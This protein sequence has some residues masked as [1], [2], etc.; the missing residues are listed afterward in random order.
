LCNDDILIIIII[1]LILISRLTKLA[2]LFVKTLA[3]PLSKRIKHDFSRYKVTKQML[4]GIGQTSHVITSRLQIWS[5][6]YRVRSITPLEPE[7]A[8]QNGAEFFGETFILC[9]SGAIVIFEYDRSTQSAKQKEAKKHQ[10]QKAENAALQA[11][12][13]SLDLRLK[14]VEDVVKQNSESILNI[15]RRPKYVEPSLSEL[16]PID[17]GDNDGDDEETTTKKDQLQAAEKSTTSINPW[18]KIW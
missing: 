9:V 6:G 16:V 2:G 14:A 11:K 4:V 10:Q 18:W 12:L 5:A 17:D 7:K 13:N 15:G 3:K 1:I 8:L